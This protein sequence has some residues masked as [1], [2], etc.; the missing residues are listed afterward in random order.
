VSTDVKL[1][2]NQSLIGCDVKCF[3]PASAIY[4]TTHLVENSILVV[5]D[6]LTKKNFFFSNDDLDLADVF[7]L[8]NIE[9]LITFMR[10]MCTSLTSLAIVES[11]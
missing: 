3:F 6:D 1:T 7:G 5:E 9:E 10:R 2:A 11:N 8:V 4:I